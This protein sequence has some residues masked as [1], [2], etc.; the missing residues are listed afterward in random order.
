[1]GPSQGNCMT[2]ACGDVP[3]MTVAPSAGEEAANGSEEIGVFGSER[4]ACGFG[5][6]PGSRVPA[7]QSA[8]T[9]CCRHLVTPRLVSW[10]AR[11][12]RERPS[13]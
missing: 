8:M 6:D 2:G 12:R 4:R 11:T 7:R 1:M 3:G 10:G 5:P 13:A 9:V